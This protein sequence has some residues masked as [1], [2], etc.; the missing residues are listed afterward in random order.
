MSTF[1]GFA[2]TG[3]GPGN[4]TRDKTIRVLQI[5]WL[6]Q[7]NDQTVDDLVTRFGVSRRTIYRDLEVLGKAKLPLVSQHMGRG[8]RL[9]AGQELFSVP[10]QERTQ[11]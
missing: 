4:G 9:L 10:P 5:A 2:K 3:S 8:Y 6:L 1:Q 11:A 7:K